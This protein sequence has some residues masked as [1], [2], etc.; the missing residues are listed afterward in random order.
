MSGFLRSGTVPVSE[1]KECA[2]K[3][4]NL[5]EQA[6]EGIDVE[7]LANDGAAA[8]TPNVMTD[9]T[10]SDSLGRDKDPAAGGGSLYMTHWL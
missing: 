6:D 5:S 7:T 8:T 1:N 4:N 3:A 2:G 10:V 9:R